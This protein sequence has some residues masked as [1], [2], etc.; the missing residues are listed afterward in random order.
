MSSRLRSATLTVRERQVL[1]AIRD[2]IAARGY[3]PTFTE[4]IASTGL[5]SRAGVA[6]VLAQL[7]TKG[8]IERD[9]GTPRGI[10]V[11]HLQAA[12]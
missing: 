2:A 1:D 7:E 9:P 10:R 12:P 5:T 6:Y 8:A 11:M 3:P 4:L